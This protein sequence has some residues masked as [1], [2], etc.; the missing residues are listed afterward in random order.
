L[1]TTAKEIASK[2]GSQSS[3]PV[4]RHAT[5]KK[6]YNETRSEEANLEA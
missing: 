1:N 3:F 4:K 2:L 6:N 5:R